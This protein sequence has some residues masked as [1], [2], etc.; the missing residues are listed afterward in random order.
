M[1]N[2]NIW[3]E[4]WYFTV[5]KQFLAGHSLNFVAKDC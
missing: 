1:L 2:C 5:N 3:N 4:D